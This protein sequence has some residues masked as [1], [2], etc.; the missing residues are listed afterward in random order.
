MKYFIPELIGRNG[1]I[2]ESTGNNFLYGF[3]LSDGH[4][5]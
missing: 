3:G 2:K 4:D 5:G 1:F